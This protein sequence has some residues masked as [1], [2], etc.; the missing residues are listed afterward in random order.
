[1]TREAA[2]YGW[3]RGEG[4][5]PFHRILEPLRVMAEHGVP[6]S[7]GDV[8][9]NE[10]LE[11]VDT[12]VASTLHYEDDTRAWHE[13]ADS[14]YHRL[15]LDV[16]DWLWA[17]DMKVLRD[18]YPREEI[19]RL[20]SNVERAH[21]ITTPSP[22]IAS[23]MARLN[24]NVWVV[25]NTVPAYTLDIPRPGPDQGLW[26]G[27]QGALDRQ[28]DWR[29]VT[30]GVARFLTDHPDW[31]FGIIGEGGIDDLGTDRT[32]VKPWTSH[33]PTYYASVA[34]FTVGLGP[35]RDT[36]F[37]RAKSSLRA[38]EYAA[39]GVVPVLPDLPPYR[40]AI[41]DGYNGLLVHSHQTL[42]GRLT[43]LAANP[44]MIAKLSVNARQSATKWTTEAA[45][46]SWA[47]AWNSR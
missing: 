20:F 28:H 32:W 17:P 33:R 1:M 22:A 18:A 15:V 7:W 44:D 38:V 24:R 27:W 2:V 16:D 13:L 26:L 40:T 34:A 10:I 23:H 3:T 43:E 45:I 11:Q 35:L 29:S 41:N 31:G 39:L 9:S 37:N 36:P 42:R 8:I 25:P 21:V 5:V 4:G 46:E 12:V 47:E 30:R 14:G 19:D 6:T